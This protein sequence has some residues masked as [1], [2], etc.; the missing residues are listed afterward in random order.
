MKRFFALFLALTLLLSG[1]A[2]GQAEQKQ[3]SATFLTVF[4]T[5]TTIVGR[6]ASEEEFSRKAQ[7]VHD[8]LLVYHQLFDIY[9]EYEGLNNLKTIN[10]HPGEAIAVDQAIIDLLL[11]CK[12]Y[13]PGGE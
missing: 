1:C 11:D 9:N 4:D 13:H 6:D 12:V 3:Y 8:E 5:V 10:D 2:G 7:A